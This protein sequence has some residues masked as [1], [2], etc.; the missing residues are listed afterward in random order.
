MP[1]P[2]FL[3]ALGQT[4][5]FLVLTDTGIKAHALGSA[6][7]VLTGTH[8]NSLFVANVACHFFECYAPLPEMTNMRKDV[9]FASALLS[10]ISTTLWTAP[11]C[12][13]KKNRSGTGVIDENR[14]RNRSDVSE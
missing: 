7:C 13:H 12:P 4:C 11:P 3:F 8:P 10:L 5:Y 14:Q 6:D 2:C 1:P 9:L